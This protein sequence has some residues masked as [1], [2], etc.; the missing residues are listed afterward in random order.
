MEQALLE[1]AT[2]GEQVLNNGKTGSNCKLGE[3]YF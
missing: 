3:K 2:Q 1:K